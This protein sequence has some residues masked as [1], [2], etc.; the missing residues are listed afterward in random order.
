VTDF[1]VNR[2]KIWGHPGPLTQFGGQCL[3]APPVEKPLQKEECLTESEPLE[4]SEEIIETYSLV[5]RRRCIWC[6]MDIIAAEVDP[7]GLNANWSEIMD[8]KGSV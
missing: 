8:S 2:Q 4:K 3:L 5:S 1:I 7:V 6:V